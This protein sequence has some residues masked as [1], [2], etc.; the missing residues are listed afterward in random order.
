[1]LLRLFCKYRCGGSGA[2]S[3]AAVGQGIAHQGVV[4]RQELLEGLV[5]GALD[6]EYQAAQ[7]RFALEAAED[8]GMG[9]VPHAAPLHQHVIDAEAAVV[10]PAEVLAIDLEELAVKVSAAGGEPALHAAGVE[11]EVGVRVT[12]DQL[13]VQQGAFRQDVLARF[14]VLGYVDQVEKGVAAGVVVAEVDAAVAAQIAEDRQHQLVA[15]PMHAADT[16]LLEGGGEAAGA[17]TVEAQ[18]VN[19]SISRD[20]RGI[21]AHRLADWDRLGHRVVRAQ[22]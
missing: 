22:R 19:A 6:V 3:L 8:L 4:L 18:H 2:S 17:A 15:V 12:V 21:D 11:D 14:T 9:L 10:K 16:G 20:L 7:L 13:L 5:G 1:M